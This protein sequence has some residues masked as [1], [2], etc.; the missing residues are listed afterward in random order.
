L[1][2]LVQCI[3]LGPDAES[4]GSQEA[5]LSVLQLERSCALSYAVGQPV[6]HKL[7]I[8]MLRSVQA[9]LERGR[10]GVDDEN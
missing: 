9:N 10:S 1:R 8:A 6:K 3:A 5:P 2:G 7:F 4:L